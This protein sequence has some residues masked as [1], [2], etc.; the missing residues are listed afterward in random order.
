MATNPEVVEA[1]QNVV[2]ARAAS[3]LAKLDYVPDIAVSGGY[4]SQNDALPPLP[5][6]FS[7]V[8]V[9]GAYTLF[10]FG[11]REHTVKERK[12]QVSMAEIALQLTKFK[13]EAGVKNSFFELERSRQLSELTRRL[14]SGAHLQNASHGESSSQAAASKARIEAEMYR[15][16]L[17]YR[18]ALTQLKTLTGVG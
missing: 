2:K 3:K 16:D 8:G 13:V 4:V 10:D 1:E 17:E 11:K 14:A 6:D 7:F 15:S 18:Q 9:V 12:A 5:R